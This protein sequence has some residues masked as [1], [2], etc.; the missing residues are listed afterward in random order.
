MGLF[1]KEDKKNGEVQGAEVLSTRV[2]FSDLPRTKKSVL[3]FEEQNVHTKYVSSD[4]QHY[5]ELLRVVPR[6]P[7]SVSLLLDG[8]TLLGNAEIRQHVDFLINFSV[9]MSLGN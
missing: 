3:L 8:G 6:N 9:D 4:E 2:T 7:S 5:I 1:K